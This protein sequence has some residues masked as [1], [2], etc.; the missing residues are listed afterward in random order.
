MKIKIFVALV[1]TGTII[2]LS[3]NWFRSNKK[4]V[5]NPLVGEWRIDSVSFAKDSNFTYFLFAGENKPDSVE[6]TFTKVTAFTRSKD[7]VDTVGYEFDAKTNQLIVEDSSQIFSF[8][9][10]N[11]SLISL[12]T[13]DSTI[14]ILQKK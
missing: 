13:K 1:A 8:A 14:L 3:C 4:E 7:N 11:D 9:K 6:V 5:G 10:I 2:F 12:T